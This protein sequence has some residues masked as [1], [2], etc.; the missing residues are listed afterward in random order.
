MFSEVFPQVFS[1]ALVFV[2]ALP[3]YN[4]TEQ[5]SMEIPAGNFWAV[6]GKCNWSHICP[7]RPHLRGWEKLHENLPPFREISATTHSFSFS[8]YKETNSFVNQP[9]NPSQRYQQINSWRTDC[10]WFVFL[11]LG[12]HL[13]KACWQLRLYRCLLSQWVMWNRR[14]HATSRC[15]FQ[16][17]L[18]CSQETD[19][20]MGW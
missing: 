5:V 10:T 15:G 18:L 19:I 3:Q 8:L 4:K 11:S 13:P 1:F 7:H 17:I 2:F 12:Q 14:L 16:V 9:P 6:L 20:L